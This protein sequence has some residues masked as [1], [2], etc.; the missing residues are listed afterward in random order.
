MLCATGST[1]T[2]IRRWQSWEGMCMPLF[3]SDALK[4]TVERLNGRTVERSN[5]RSYLNCI[6]VAPFDRLDSAKEDEKAFLELMEKAVVSGAKPF[7]IL[8]LLG[9]GNVLDTFVG[10]ETLRGVSGGEK[11]RVT[12]SEA[13][14][15]NARV[16]CMDEISTGLDAV[17]LFSFSCRQL[18]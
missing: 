7:I 17:S 14:V 3:S 5:G 9:L 15:T 16:L 8:N 18:D 13:L 1:W 6:A 2:W 10:D 11:K 4:G 12:I